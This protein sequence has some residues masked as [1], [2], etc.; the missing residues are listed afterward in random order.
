LTRLPGVTVVTYFM[1]IRPAY[2]TFAIV[3]SPRLAARQIRSY[4]RAR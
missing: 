4:N 2:Q 3:C 1:A